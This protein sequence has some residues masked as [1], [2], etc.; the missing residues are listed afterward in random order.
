MLRR[1]GECHACAECC[2]TVNITAVRDLTLSQHGSLEEL[3]RYLGYRGIRV[4]GQ[5]EERNLLFYEMDVPCSQ[6]GPDNKCKVHGTPEKPLLCERYPTE[7]GDI[8]ACGYRFEKALPGM[9][10]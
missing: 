2:Q 1:T 6:L 8:E 5:D 7:P 10:G 3:E 9:P 4:V